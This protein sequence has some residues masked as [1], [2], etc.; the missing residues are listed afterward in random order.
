[1]AEY[2]LPA[3][4]NHILNVTKYTQIVYIGHS[5]GTLIGFAKFS[6]DLKF[7]RKV[8]I[9]CYSSFLWSNENCVD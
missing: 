3:M 4:T 1:M 8:I 2:D 5:Q 6:S 9:G 7:A